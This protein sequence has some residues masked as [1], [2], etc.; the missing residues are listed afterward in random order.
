MSSIPPFITAIRAAK[1]FPVNGKDGIK[2]LNTGVGWYIDVPSSTI[3][4][5]NADGDDVEFIHT[6][7]F[8]THEEAETALAIARI[9]GIAL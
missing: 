7:P 4:V 3:A 8:A 2:N 1:D 5:I 6:P 9:K